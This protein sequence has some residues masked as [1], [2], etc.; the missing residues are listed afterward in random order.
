MRKAAAQAAIKQRVS[1]RISSSLDDKESVAIAMACAMRQPDSV[2]HF[3]TTPHMG[4]AVRGLESELA[5]RADEW[6]ALFCEPDSLWTNASLASLVAQE[7]FLSIWG[8]LRLTF[9][10]TLS[11][12]DAMRVFETPLGKALLYVSV[13]LS[14]VKT[15]SSDLFNAAVTADM[16]R[17]DEFVAEIDDTGPD[18]LSLVRIC[19]EISNG[20]SI[21]A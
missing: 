13:H 15:R 3:L 14:D 17:I 21:N 8:R 20:L 2:V 16:R 12:K 1:N 7:P 10:C 6:H 11:E 18:V 9:R 19:L 4:C 5:I